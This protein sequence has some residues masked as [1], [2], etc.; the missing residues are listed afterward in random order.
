MWNLKSNTK[1]LYIKQGQTHRQKTYSY[2]PKGKG[3]GGR[4][5]ECGSVGMW[6]QI[7]TSQVVLMVKNPLANAEDVR[8]RVR[9][10]GGEEHG[11]PGRGNG[12][13][14]QYSCLEDPM[15]RGA[16]QATFHS[17]AQSQSGLKQLSTHT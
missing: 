15:D 2:L 4:V 13:P 17:I 14:L 1:N 12:N 16:W 9:S 5:G 6:E 8:G 7:W 3:S 10:L 11:I